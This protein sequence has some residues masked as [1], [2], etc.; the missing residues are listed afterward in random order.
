MPRT[1]IDYSKTLIYKLVHKDDFENEDVYVGSTT[2]FRRRKNNH[3]TRCNN[4]TTKGYNYK[5]YQNIREN[6]GWDEWVMIEIEKF[7]CK[8]KREVN[9]RERYWCE[10]YKSNLNIKVPGRTR[11]EWRDGHKDETKEYYET[12]KDEKHKYYLVHKDKIKE[13]NKEYSK[14][15]KEHRN[16]QSREKITCECGK[17]M[18]KSSLW[19]HKNNMCT[20][21]QVA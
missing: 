6:G 2:D 14:T 8:D 10:F 16:T 21:L 17:T 5:V 7:P 3:K 19:I 18:N 20:L 1:P 11:Q 12:H 4:P 15:N 13:Y 9:A